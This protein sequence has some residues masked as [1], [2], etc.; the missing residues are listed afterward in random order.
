[1]QF[2]SRGLLLGLIVVALVAACSPAAAGP[3]VA[4]LESQAPGGSASPSPSLSPEDALLAYARCM[5]EHGV[6]M[7]DP[8]YQKNDDGSTVIGI[9]GGGPANSEADKTKFAEADRACHSLLAAVM[10]GPGKG[11]MTPEEEEK[12]LQF[13]R[14]MRE[15][16][17]DFPD[18]ADGGF[19]F[20]AGP[21]SGKSGMDPNDPDFKA[22]QE[23]CGSLLPGRIDGKGPSLN[24]GTEGGPATKA[25]R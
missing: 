21:S 3:G 9:G 16:G 18:P 11:Q 12:L 14:C 1:M 23:A 19:T 24:S 2:K 6:D 5:R 20:D 8:E 15:H 25:V 7:P 13:A 4:T 10:Q 22:A 17:I